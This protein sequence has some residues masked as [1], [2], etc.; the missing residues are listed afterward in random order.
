[1]GD[2]ILNFRKWTFTESGDLPVPGMFTHHLYPAQRSERRNGQT[3]PKRSV[4]QETRL[5]QNSGHQQLGNGG[6]AGQGVSCPRA[7]EKRL[8]D[9]SPRVNHD[10]REERDSRAWEIK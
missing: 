9:P 2:G 10:N 7:R 6:A 4:S 8:V 1:M 5:K 3:D